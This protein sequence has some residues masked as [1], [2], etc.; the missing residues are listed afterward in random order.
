MTQMINTITNYIDA[1]RNGRYQQQPT[2]HKH[3]ELIDATADLLKQQDVTHY[4]TLTFAKPVSSWT[5][6]SKYM[7]WIDCLEWFQRRPLG[8]LRAE[9]TMRWSGCDEAVPAAIPLHYHGLLISAPHL[10]IPQAKALW[11]EIAGDA[12]VRA[13]D[14]QGGAIPYCLKHAFHSCGD[15]ELGGLKAFRRYVPIEC[16]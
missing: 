1:S 12:D 4:F 10:T 11:R 8:W 7:E 15:Y 16:S 6:R 2:S 3:Q 5:A 9:E 13:Y 14:P